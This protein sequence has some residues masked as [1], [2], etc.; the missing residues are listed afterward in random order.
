MQIFPLELRYAWR[1]ARRQPVVTL[2]II[3]LLA[4]GMGGITTVF[5]PIYS[6][7]FSPLP[8]PH[9][10]QLFRIGGNIPFIN[11]F[12]GIFEHEEILDGIFSNMFAYYE[13]QSK[14][15]IPD[16]GK[17]VNVNILHVAENFFA[18]LGV[19][20]FM[21]SIFSNNEDHVGFIVSH[22]FWQRELVGK[23]DVIRK[24]YFNANW[25]AASNYRNNA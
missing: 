14:I 1:R 25:R 3:L 21:G 11:G 7:I 22:K 10:E 8:F 2:S 16:T 9:P 19:K 17:Q 18:T 15:S 23:P 24:L 12:T 4:L 20:P 5:N 6:T 13:Q